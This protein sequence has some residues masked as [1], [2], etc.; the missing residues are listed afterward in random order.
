MRRPRRARQPARTQSP[1]R[2][3]PMAVRAGIEGWNG[4]SHAGS[5][6]ARSGGARS[7]LPGSGAAAVVAALAILGGVGGAAH[8]G[9]V[10]AVARAHAV[11]LGGGAITS[12]VELDEAVW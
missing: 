10:A 8:G 12:V 5:D 1:T 2:C 9:G 6:V 11:R 4:G 3:A 7:S